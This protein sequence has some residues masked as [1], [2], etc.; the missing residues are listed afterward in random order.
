M[1]KQNPTA[2][3]GAVRIRSVHVAEH[4]S[5]VV[6][7]AEES[8]AL[9]SWL[10]GTEQ[11]HRGKATG[12]RFRLTVDGV[13]LDVRRVFATFLHREP[14]QIIV[15]TTAGGDTRAAAIGRRVGRPVHEAVL[16]RVD[17]KS[18]KRQR[19]FPGLEPVAERKKRITVEVEA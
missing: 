10:W 5:S 8:A 15:A 12:S 19:G 2:S 1:E 7:V 13:T 16:V 3:L 14:G 18:D 9:C 11:I 6:L 17:A 4:H